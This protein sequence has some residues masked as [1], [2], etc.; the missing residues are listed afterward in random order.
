APMLGPS[1]HAVKPRGNDVSTELRTFLRRR[2]VISPNQQLPP[3]LSFIDGENLVRDLGLP[4]QGM[5]AE[6]LPRGSPRKRVS[7]I[8]LVALQQRR[9][10][11]HLLPNAEC[12]VAGRLEERDRTR[13]P[14]RLEG[15]QAHHS[16][17]AAAD[18]FRFPRVSAPRRARPERPSGPDPL[19][20]SPEFPLR[21][22]SS[23][24][25]SAGAAGGNPKCLRVPA[26]VLV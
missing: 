3:R 8:L 14:L 26:R 13:V 9:D 12:P 16:L 18:P 6:F 5:E 4:L 7:A 23:E 25:L 20:A 10:R 22:G 24:D 2:N 19:P 1:N 15:P 17:G 21:R 11:L